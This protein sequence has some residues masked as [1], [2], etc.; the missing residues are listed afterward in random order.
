[1]TSPYRNEV[2]ALRDRKALLERELEQLRAQAADLESL[3]ARQAAV[4]R[5]L[6]T[7]SD[8]LGASTKR[9]LPMLE[10]VTVASPC[11]ARWD[12]MV[13]DDRVRFCPSCEKNVYN[14]SAMDRDEAERLLQERA[15]KG[16]CIRFCQRADGTVMTQDCPVGVSRKRRKV[17]AVAFG[18]TALAAAATATIFDRTCRTVQG[19]PAVVGQM[20][21]DAPAPSAS[22]A[23]FVMG[24]VEVER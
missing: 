23:P 15:G 5:E 24:E 13:G 1:V 2:D 11:P 10:R 3:K 22:P 9:A 21:V 16:L 7:V 6:R 8:K 20:V 12:D 14:L 18:A 4:E 19:E 17:V